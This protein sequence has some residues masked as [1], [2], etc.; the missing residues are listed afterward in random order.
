MARKKRTIAQNL[1]KKK[2]PKE[3]WEL[4][5]QNKR[6]K[7]LVDRLIE[8]K[9]DFEIK[10]R[11]LDEE[12]L[13]W[14]ADWLD[15]PVHGVTGQLIGDILMHP[16]EIPNPKENP[17]EFE[18]FLESGLNYGKPIE[19]QK[20]I[21]FDAI[22][23]ALIKKAEAYKK[24]EP[25]SEEDKLELCEYITEEHRRIRQGVWIWIKG[26]LYHVV[27]AYY[28]YIQYWTM[29]D[30]R[31]P[32]FRESDMEFFQFMEYCAQ[33]PFCRGFAMFGRRQSGKSSAIMAFLEVHSI[34]MRHSEFGIQSK[35]EKDA[36]ALFQDCLVK[37]WKNAP[38]FLTPTYKGTDDPTKA[39]FHASPVEINTKKK[40]E[41]G[42]IIE[43]MPS[44][45]TSIFTTNSQENA[46]DSR[47]LSFGIADEFGKTPDINI[48]RR[49]NV[50]LQATAKYLMMSTVEEMGGGQSLEQSTMLWE[51]S[52][53]NE[54]GANGYTKSMLYR[55]FIPANRCFEKIGENKSFID[56]WG[57]SLDEEAKNYIV[58]RR[59]DLAESPEELIN[60]TRYSPLTIEEAL[61]PSAKDGI[62]KNVHL[63]VERE[64][65]IRMENKL[66]KNK[67]RYTIGN[68]EWVNSDFST[69]TN[70]HGF[71]AGI[72]RRETRVIFV[73]N[74]KGRFKLLTN[75]RLSKDEQC[76]VE[77]HEAWEDSNTNYSRPLY[78]FRPVNTHL[79]AAIDGIKAKDVKDS[80]RAS[81]G[82]MAVLRVRASEE[83]T[84]TDENGIEIKP[85]PPK[86]ICIYLARP[87]EA[88]FADD[89]AKALF[90]F[91]C[92]AVVE[93]VDGTTMKGLIDLGMLPF[94][95][96]EIDVKD[97]LKPT[98]KDMI[99]R[100]QHTGK[101]EHDAIGKAIEDYVEFH[102]NEIEFDQITGQWKSLTAK[103][104]TKLDLVISTG[105][106]LLRAS[107][108]TFKEKYDKGKDWK[109][110]QT[111][112]VVNY[113]RDIF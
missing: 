64:A 58:N 37:G 59:T 21:R 92:Q 26:T 96:H 107:M 72:P 104:F 2:L 27:G 23:K 88:I 31:A 3:L 12:E 28:F 5:S 54:R 43:S 99:S 48:I 7:S 18:A 77:Y 50:V 19:E 34:Q 100:G 6:K 61:M 10:K 63:L 65:K 35:T 45:N 87:V 83:P 55:Y 60:E 91:G 74:L 56:E 16:P 85:F 51:D 49:K 76:N 40:V 15:I 33:D 113:I 38:Y 22:P 36:E 81:K 52:D 101:A 69:K 57:F 29:K 106:C 84:K 112:N 82:S 67:D 105:Y 14:Y 11:E 111:S 75:G 53:P 80:K 98:F 68:F 79:I 20:F 25:L 4:N 102:C 1:S 66:N 97:K 30:G 103:N 95:S 47:T 32:K 62:I 46:L 71:K 9:K 44:L 78:E 24:G 73:P 109:Q 90:F 89:M 108:K 8:K 93:D 94:I 70:I 39:L 42:H 17:K 110:F 13:E 86:F 41:Q